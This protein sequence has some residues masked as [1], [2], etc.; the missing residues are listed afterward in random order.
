MSR[1][2]FRLSLLACLALV[3]ACSTPEERFAKHVERAE[4]HVE[5]GRADDAMIELQSALKLNPE[6]ADVNEKLATLLRNREALQA[7]AFHYGEAY[8]IDPQRIDAGLAQAELLADTAP[9]R[10][11]QLIARALA[12]HPDDARVHRSESRL[13]AKL[14]RTTRALAAAE[15]GL[16]LAPDDPDSWSQLGSAHLALAKEQIQ[17]G[18]PN[19]ET[20][21]AGLDAFQKVDDMTGGHV[22]ARLERARLLGRWPGHHDEA[23]RTYRS[24]IALAKEQGGASGVAF[25][26]MRLARYAARIGDPKLRAEA[27]REI[28]TATPDRVQVWEQLAQSASLSEG[29][30]AADGVYQALLESQ[31]ESPAA[32]AAY[33]N[34]LSKRNRELDAIAHLDRVITDGLD[35]PILWEQLVR[36]EISQR[37]LADAKASLEEMRSRHGDAVATQR[38]NARVAL[39]EGRF[40]DAIAALR[41]VGAD[42]APE[43]ERLRALAEVG[44]GNFDAARAAIGRAMNRPGQ[45]DLATL[46]L[47]ASIEDRARDPEAVLATFT[48]IRD[49]G[50]TLSPLESVVRARALYDTARPA[51]GRTVLVDLLEGQF[52]VPPAA[53]EFA[54]REGVNAPSEAHA[55]L[56]R[57]LKLAPGNFAALESITELE[58]R[59]NQAASALARLDKLVESQLA[60]ANVLLLRARI[61]AASGQLDRAEADALRAFEASPNLDRAVDVLYGIYAAQGKIQEALASFEEADSVGV[62]HSGARVLLGRLYMTTGANDKAKAMYERVIEENPT[63]TTAKNDLAFLLATTGSDTD[64]ALA[65]A[66]DAQRARPHDPAVADTVGFVYLKKGRNEVA[67]Q[68]FRYAIEIGTAQGMTSPAVHYH[69]GLALAALGRDDEAKQAFEE[70]LAIN[71]SFQD[72]PDAR[73]RLAATGE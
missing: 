63:S 5:A 50:H 15:K 37:R 55:Y 72:A 69:M 18:A 40:T 56:Q 68:Q 30:E 35:A 2:Y 58:L 9:Q 27:L 43:T 70:A 34:F 54:R 49:L 52:P 23:V 3:L 13:A 36:L 31:P 66:E 21:E 41:N 24:A 28:V 29:P 38:A 42:T 7:A 26:A 64:R 61:L 60:G 10:A 47:K 19:P 17:A 59:S 51:Q 48:Q 73:R 12:A 22:G 8:R 33:T 62:L 1:G 57:A 65:L 46:R 53:V 67:L 16:E 11:E 25:A 71:P 6:N 14:G 4:A 45:G 32:H 44:A 39:R 20:F